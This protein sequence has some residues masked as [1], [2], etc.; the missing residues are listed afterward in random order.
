[1]SLNKVILIGRL[2]KDPE[3]RYT[4]NGV[5][6]CQFT[7]AVD[8]PFA[9]QN[10]E[11]E[12]DF[13]PVVAWRQT[14]EACA[15]YVKKGQQVAVDGRIQTRSYENNEGRKVYITEVIAESIQFLNPSSQNGQPNGQSA[16][17]P[18][19]NQGP[20]RNGNN[21]N[22]GSGNNTRQQNSGSGQNDGSHDWGISDDDLPF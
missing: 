16:E 5:A 8:R 21:R 17:Q 7:L 14:A 6:V 18:A 10:G 4:T 9:N 12:A 3:L 19:N 11:R 1:M 13:L 22:P 20:S 15:N 2:T